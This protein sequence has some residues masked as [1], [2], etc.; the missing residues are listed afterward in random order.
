MN[1]SVNAFLSLCRVNAQSWLHDWRTPLQ[2][3]VVKDAATV[4]ALIAAGSKE[5][6]VKDKVGYTIGWR[7]ECV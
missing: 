4:K 2:E 3:A 6:G 1:A 5:T 7:Q